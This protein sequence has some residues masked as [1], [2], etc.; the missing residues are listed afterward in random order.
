MSKRDL[1]SLFDAFSFSFQ[2]QLPSP[3]NIC[4][5]YCYRN[6]CWSP[7]ESSLNCIKSFFLEFTPNLCVET[8]A[9]DFKVES[10]TD[11]QNIMFV[12]YMNIFYTL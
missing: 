12:Y 4:L 11:A 7:F 8:Y 5:T 1:K 2:D 9:T 6:L 10:I 3:T